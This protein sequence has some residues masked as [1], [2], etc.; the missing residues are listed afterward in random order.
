ME[1]FDVDGLS[2]AYE[3]RGEGPP[4]VL[5]HGGLIDHREWRHQ[6][7]GLSDEFTVVA[8]DAPGCGAS[9]DP[10]E[11]FRMAEY[12]DC[13]AALIESI[14]LERPHVLGLSWGSTLAL[15]L[16]RRRPDLPRSLV[17]TAAYAGWAGSL[18]PEEV[19]E[20]LEGF[21]PQMDRP[22][23]EW[24][25]EYIPTLLTHRAPKAMADELVEIMA[26][27]RQAGLRPMLLAMAG[28][29]LRDVL[30][31]ISVPTLLLYG[32]ED[33]RSPIEVAK[34][35]HAAIPG[36]TLVVLPE[37]GHQSNVEAPDRFNDAVRTFL[38]AASY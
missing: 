31:T 2:I 19:A 38:R 28:A 32:E 14:G 27:S 16:Y 18:P 1:R 12:A 6:L 5:V 13:L 30:P 17:L 34:E 20:R 4:L 11:T 26:D 37:V 21:L 9:S 24:V 8:W 7:D 35:M 29:D 22:A 3:R 23:R 33:V 10:P 15:E 36:S 25:H